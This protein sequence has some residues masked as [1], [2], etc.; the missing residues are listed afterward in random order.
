MTTSPGRRSPSCTAA[1]FTAWCAAEPACPLILPWQRPADGGGGARRI[2]G[3]SRTPRCCG[4]CCRGWTTRC[5][6]TRRGRRR[7]RCRRRRAWRA[8]SSTCSATPASS[9]PLSAGSPLARTPFSGRPLYTLYA[10]SKYLVGHPCTKKERPAGKRGAA[11]VHNRGDRAARGAGRPRADE[12]PGKELL[13]ARRRLPGDQLRRGDGG[14]LPL[15]AAV[16][17]AGVD[18]DEGGGV[19]RLLRALP[20]GGGRA[21]ADAVRQP[22][23]RAFARAAVGRRCRAPLSDGAV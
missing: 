12:A 3:S 9:P 19:P 22:P 1:S 5:G 23:G 10:S 16:S 18:R 8:A 4:R 2:I 17:H 21:Q 7:V 15:R 13:G 14:G 6:S 11:D 20:G